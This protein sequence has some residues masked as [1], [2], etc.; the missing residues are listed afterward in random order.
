MRVVLDPP[1]ARW[2]SVVDSE[3]GLGVPHAVVLRGQSCCD[4]VPER[5]GLSD[6]EYPRDVFV[7]DERGRANVE[8]F[9]PGLFAAMAPG[10]Q[11]ARWLR[12]H[13]PQ[14]EP[15]TI[16]LTRGRD[17]RGRV[18][19]PPEVRGLL[20]FSVR[21]GEVWGGRTDDRGA[22]ALRGLAFETSILTA[23][24]GAGD[25]PCWGQVEV[26]ATAD[27]AEIPLAAW[28]PGG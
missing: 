14:S 9:R 7:C 25:L 24:G 2:M 8:P 11:T 6:V 23:E 26:D 21:A 28:R 10:Y 22:F 15:A 13:E 4:P 12:L 5:P 18:A 20:R 1:P 17:V 27:T 19:I 3:T 16:A